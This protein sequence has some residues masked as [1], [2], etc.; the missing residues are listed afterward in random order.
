VNCAAVSGFL[1][2]ILIGGAKYNQPLNCTEFG[3]LN[4]QY[5]SVVEVKEALLN[6]LK[7][8]AIGQTI[9]YLQMGK[10]KVLLLGE[11]EQ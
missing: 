10:P 5:W 6:Q 3:P 1:H 7:V 4:K 9:W 8:P 11:I 2:S